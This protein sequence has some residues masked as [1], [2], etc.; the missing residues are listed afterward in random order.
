MDNPFLYGPVATGG[1]FTDRRSEL[2]ELKADIKAGQDVVLISPRRYGKTSLVWRAMEDLH[3]DGVLT[4]YIDLFRQDSKQQLADALSRAI[5]GGLIAP[6]ERAMRR[7]AQVFQ[8]LAIRPKV[9]IG[10]DGTPNFEFEVA[11]HSRDLDQTIEQLLELPGRIAHDR[12]RPVALVLDEFQRVIEIDPRLPVVMRSIFQFQPQVAH[13]FLGSKRHLMAKVF[14]DQNEPL[15]RLAKPIPLGPIGATDFGRFIAERFESTGIEISPEAVDRILHLT[16]GRPADTQEICHFAWAI[17]H[18]NSEPAT[19]ETVRRALDR[20]LDAENYR[21]QSL[22]DN[23]SRH[24]RLTLAALAREGEMI[25]SEG[26]RHR[27]RVGSVASVQKSV[28]RLIDLEI[29]EQDRDGAYRIP[30]VF[31]GAWITRPPIE[32]QGRVRARKAASG[33]L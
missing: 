30:D 23:L 32:P 10:P 28:N 33:N 19:P 20:V 9:S 18:S 22:W 7:A 6:F 21:Y 31:F 1:A 15:Y 27:H 12:K 4:A 14:S 16:G 11:E 24:Q 29:I 17:A 13:V 26:Y 8:F 25:Y 5:Y 2:A 3:S